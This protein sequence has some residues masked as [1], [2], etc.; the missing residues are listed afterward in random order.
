[1]I[2]AAQ[3]CP[4][5]QG[6]LTFTAALLPIPGAL[7]R[8]T[9]AGGGRRFVAG[10]GC[11]RRLPVPVAGRLPV[12]VPVAGRLPAPVAGTQKMCIMDSVGK[13]NSTS[14]ITV[15]IRITYGNTVGR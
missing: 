14:K 6:E 7:F 3:P 10:A 4:I 5:T 12:P 2:A 1:M 15:Y 13:F 9:V 8:Y 11:R